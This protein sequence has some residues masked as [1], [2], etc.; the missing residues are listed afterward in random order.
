MLLKVILLIVFV[1]VSE[2]F[3]SYRHVVIGKSVIKVASQTPETPPTSILSNILKVLPLASFA[4]SAAGV[5]FQIFVLYPW[6]EELSAEFKELEEAIVSLDTHLEK[7]DPDLE[8]FKNN[9]RILTLKRITDKYA[10]S[11]SSK[12]AGPRISNILPFVVEKSE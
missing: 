3:K 2:S 6:H 1:F 10:S 8:D 12:T 7:V 4:L 11:L 9:D 5:S